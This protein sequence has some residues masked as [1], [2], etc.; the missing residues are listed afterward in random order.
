MAGNGEGDLTE[1]P[2]VSCG[3]A[4]RTVRNSLPVP[5][6]VLHSQPY[7]LEFRQHLAVSLE[8]FQ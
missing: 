1:M 6:T 3:R 4:I 5:S 8:A 7:L 2:S